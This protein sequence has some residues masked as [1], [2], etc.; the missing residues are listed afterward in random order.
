MAV[1]DGYSSYY[2]FCNFIDKIQPIDQQCYHTARPLRRVNQPILS[3][4]SHVTSR[5][6]PYSIGEEVLYKDDDHVERG[7]IERVSLG[8]DKL[9]TYEIKLKNNHTATATPSQLTAPDE[10][11]LAD[12][13]TSPQDFIANAKFMDSNELALLA[14]PLP[15]NKIEVEWKKIHDKF[16]HL[17]FAELDKLVKHGVLPSKFKSL[18]GK[19]ILC[20]SCIFGRM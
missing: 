9:T 8:P 11:E 12:I 6:D 20:P 10:T 3:D 19:Q 15:L 4:P 17:P 7:I 5:E 16:G 18:A 1:N 13:P 2:T 14:K